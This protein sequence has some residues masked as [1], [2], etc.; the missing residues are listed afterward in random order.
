[1]LR[2]PD[3]T[4][5]FLIQ[6]LRITRR[7]D[8][9]L[10][11]AR[12]LIPAPTT[13]VLELPER[14][15]RGYLFHA[16]TAGDS[17]LWRASSWT[18]PL[19]P[20]T[21]LG[22]DAESVQAGFD[23]LYVVV[24]G[25]REVVALDADTG[26][27]VD[28]GSLPATAAVRSLAFADAWFGIVDLPYRGALVTFDA[29]ASWH[30]L[31]LGTVRRLEAREGEI[32]AW[33]EAD[34]YSVDSRGR[35]MR[36][37]RPEQSDPGAPERGG[38][39]PG[40]ARPPALLREAVLRGWPEPPEHAVVIAAG[41]LSRVRLRDG[42]VV[43]RVE[44]VVDRGDRCQ[45]IALGEGFGFV[46]TREQGGTALLRF[47]PP[48]GVERQLVFG[49]PRYVAPGGGGAVAVRGACTD[50]PGGVAGGLYCI[51]GA[52]GTVREIRVRGDR[53]VER[54][55][56]LRDG[57]V[58]VLVPPRFGAQGQLALVGRDG[59]T[60]QVALTLPAAKDARRQLL[61][62]GLWLDG[63]RERRSGQLAGWV[64]GS[65]DFVGV[66]VA[67]DGRVTA[68]EPAVDLG[69]SVLSG[70]FS[71]TRSRE[72][73]LRETTDGGFSWREVDPRLDL[74]SLLA[75][76]SSEHGC[77]AL[78]CALGDWVRIGWQGRRGKPDALTEAATPR[79]AVF[80]PTEGGRWLMRC[81]L[82]RTGRAGPAP[83]VVGAGGGRGKAPR[84]APSSPTMTAESV[85]STAWAPFAGAPPPPL[86]PADVGLDADVAGAL[87]VY[88]AGAR[89]AD[90]SR[91]ARWRV[92]G[93]DP[94]DLTGEVWS[95]AATP[96]PWP[97]VVAAAQAFGLNVYGNPSPDLAAAIEPGGRAGVLSVAAA[98]GRSL[99]VV[100]AGRAIQPIREAAAHNVL[101][102]SGVVK[103]EGS[104][105][106]GV[107]R[108]SFRVYRVASD[109]LVLV[110][111]YP[112]VEG[113][114]S[115]V[116]VVLVR[117]ARSDA[118]GLWVRVARVRGAHSS[119]FVF[120]IDAAQGS[121]E[122]PL[123]IEPRDL[124]RMP[125]PCSADDDGWVLV[126]SPP[127]APYVELE[128]VEGAWSPRR[129]DARWLA[130]PSGLCLDALSAEGQLPGAAALVPATRSSARRTV[131]MTVR[132][133][134]Q[135]T[136]RSLLR[137]S[138]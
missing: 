62:R 1:M 58:A 115:S 102:A 125:P 81:A 16:R 38:E 82:E 126:G 39:R 137:C 78:G 131:P 123:V 15:G 4:E 100:E 111:D 35:V 79:G 13:S 7:P 138:G 45:A 8:G 122:P 11:R 57:R 50:E 70:P 94:F 24:R 69:R 118:L 63:F 119:W 18:G 19:R 47:R 44:D 89:S 21:R 128:G 96:T 86:A 73:S 97:D 54:V 49:T 77:S 109:R 116:S 114:S 84:A 91:A 66:R 83:R 75:N 107:D 10:A 112:E 3:G 67:F 56:A 95:T 127:V 108:D 87:H 64:A 12:D 36:L 33:V 51:V 52:D 110:G 74:A 92:R 136:G 117:N 55:V 25:S 113:A 80:P 14:L 68:G 76:R 34:V 93:L 90:W 129:F 31:G 106:L 20:L 120:P 17:R 27:V 132:D 9:A 60:E 101:A 29:G 46:C 85:E 42:A 103:V 2:D 98:G 53:G 6:G 104:F 134:D 5:R 99:Y 43:A 40:R 30:P 61:R 65:D 32:V 22:F 71:L 121:V 41:T 26:A 133:P 88:A 130:G 37:G 59:G 135:P 28:L 48:L 105:Y 72:G 124:G 23:R